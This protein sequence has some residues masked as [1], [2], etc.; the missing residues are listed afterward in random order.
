MKR[1]FTGVLFCAVIFVF[2]LSLLAQD[3]L[4]QADTL[5][6]QGGIENILKSIPLYV[7]AIQANPDSYEANWKCARAYRE[8]GDKAKTQVIEGWKEICAKYGKEGMKY[9][10]KAI[11]LAP[12][13][14]EGH[15]YYGLCVG[16]YADGVSILTALKEGLKGKTQNA[17]EKSYEVDKM[18]ED[19]G[20]MIALGRFWAVLPWPMKK[21]KKALKY[22]RE[23]LQTFP[24]GSNKAEVQV[25]LAEVLLDTGEKD[26]AKGLL[27][28]AA[29]SDDKYYSNQA[30]DLL[31]KMK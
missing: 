4:T 9:G 29:K 28:K 16:V 19:G 12:D 20:P 1:W 14:I 24:N 21:N 11:E 8:Y 2:P 7:K 5:Y 30:K 27:E 6:D 10:E 18:Y 17:F 22:L 23:N 26:E 15:F 25:Y 3:Y 31:A 13:K